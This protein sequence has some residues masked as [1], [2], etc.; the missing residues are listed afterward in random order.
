MPRKEYIYIIRNLDIPRLKIGVSNDI[1]RRIITLQNAGG[2]RMEISW[3]SKL[4]TN[5]YFI[6]GLLHLEFRESRY[7]GE[8]FHIDLDT[9]INT[10]VK[11]VE[12]NGHE[13]EEKPKYIEREIIHEPTQETQNKINQ[14]NVKDLNLNSYKRIKPGIYIGSDDKIYS[15]KYKIDGTGWNVSELEKVD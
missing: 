14:I 6:E 2:C 5:A 3:Y 12:T 9:A 4:I 10:A 8:W 11:M 13:P 15:I 1:E 7:I